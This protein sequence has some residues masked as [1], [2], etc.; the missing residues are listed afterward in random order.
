MYMCVHVNIY[1][2]YVW[3][4]LLYILYCVVLRLPQNASATDHM[5]PDT[6]WAVQEKGEA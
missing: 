1:N 2:A 3:C 6:P 5:R 4:M